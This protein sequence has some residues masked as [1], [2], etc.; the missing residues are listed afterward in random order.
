MQKITVGCDIGGTH[1]SSAL[2]NPDF[3]SSNK[4]NYLSCRIDSKADAETILTGWTRNLKQT[5]QSLG[6]NEL[7][8]IG[9]SMP[10]PFDY[11]RG[12]SLIKGVE[13]FESLYEINIRNEFK[14]RLNLDSECQV[15][16]RNDAVCFAMGEWFGGAGK[17]FDRI[18]AVTLGTGLGSCFLSDGYQ[19]SGIDGIPEDGFLYHKP[20]KDGI[21]DEYFS[22]R[23]ILRRYK[24]I[25]GKKKDG[26][27]E[28]SILAD[29]GD[30][31]ARQAFCELGT[32][33]G[34]FLNPFLKSFNAEILI[35]GGS[36]SGARQHFFPSLKEIIDQD[37]VVNRSVL[38]EQAAI[39]GA[40]RLPLIFKEI[41]S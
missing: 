4:E 29:K 7:A 17:G 34:E 27:L 31:S 5:M 35:I 6:E 32:E 39:L 37:V 11:D 33:L 41:A 20:W 1:I 21:A 2:M 19:V 9:V 14:R 30:R 38:G 15:I 26:V 3:D 40:S 23:G 18:L 10:G 16:F 22:S 13:K 12:I 25:S 8:G 28:L 24:E 36:I